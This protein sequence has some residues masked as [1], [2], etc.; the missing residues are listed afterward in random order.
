MRCWICRRKCPVPVRPS[1]CLLCWCHSCLRRFSHTACVRWACKLQTKICQS[2][3]RS[4]FST[5]L[6][7]RPMHDAAE[8][9]RRY[10]NWFNLSRFGFNALLGTLQV[11]YETIIPANLLTGTKNQPF[12][13][14]TSQPKQMYKK[15]QT[16]AQTKG[17]QALFSDLLR[18]LARKQI[19]HTLQCTSQSPHSN[20][21][22]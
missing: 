16:F 1:P 10:L 14:I 6:S 7:I 3:K 4:H 20:I 8:I 11:I 17:T 22:W 12:Q 18:H 2:V 9:S 13:P 19:K 21:K 5:L 15:L